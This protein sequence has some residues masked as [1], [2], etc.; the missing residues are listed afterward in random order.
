VNR[1]LIDEELVRQ[2]TWTESIASG[3]E[4]YVENTQKQMG[5]MAIGRRI[6]R[7]AKCFELRE[8]QLPYNVLSDAKNRIIDQNDLFQ[9][10]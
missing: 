2:L 3:S 7:A 1:S 9:W 5:A 10:N 8:Q 4:L 6:L